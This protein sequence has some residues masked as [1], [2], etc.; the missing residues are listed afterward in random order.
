[1]ELKHT[2]ESNSVKEIALNMKEEMTNVEFLI[3][4]LQGGGSL[5]QMPTYRMLQKQV[6]HLKEEIDILVNK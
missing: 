1:M 4:R 2:N 3:S 6:N 5:A